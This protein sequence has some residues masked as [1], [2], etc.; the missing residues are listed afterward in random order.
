MLR[1]RH[2]ADP[3]GSAASRGGGAG[4]RRRH[5]HLLAGPGRLGRPSPLGSA[6]GSLAAHLTEQ[7]ASVTLITQDSPYPVR[8]PGVTLVSVPRTE[9]LKAHR[10]AVAKALHDVAPD[11]VDCSTWEAE[12]LHYLAVPRQDRAPVLVRGEFSAARLGARQRAHLRIDRPYLRAIWRVTSTASS[13]VAASRV[14]SL[15]PAGVNA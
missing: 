10:D 11:V 7:G 4:W 5:R 13:M 1:S 3:V 6:T 15:Y 14:D 2:V 9:S 12:T 8:M